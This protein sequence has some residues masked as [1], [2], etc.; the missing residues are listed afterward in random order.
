MS[1]IIPT[2]SVRGVRGW[3]PWICQCPHHKKNRSAL[4]RRVALRLLYFSIT[5]LDSR[6]HYC[7]LG[8]VAESTYSTV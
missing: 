7:R 1:K 8:L 3:I 2:V 6:H 4:P 5:L